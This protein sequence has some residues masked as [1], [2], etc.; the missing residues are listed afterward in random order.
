MSL[1]TVKPPSGPPAWAAVCTCWLWV[2]RQLVGDC[3]TLRPG[4]MTAALPG[5]SWLTS[6]GSAAELLVKTSPCP[7]LCRSISCRTRDRAIEHTGQKPK[8]KNTCV[9][10]WF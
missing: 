2:D 10:G 5:N 1:S 6:H 4:H 8:V 7:P 3:T 9:V